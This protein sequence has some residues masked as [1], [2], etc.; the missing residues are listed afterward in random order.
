MCLSKICGHPILRAPV[1]IGWT[2]WLFEDLIRVAERF[3][4]GVPQPPP[5]WRLLPESF[6]AGRIRPK[7][8][9]NG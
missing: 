9:E 3:F 2:A 1:G 8:A 6:F 5:P 4:S 7:T